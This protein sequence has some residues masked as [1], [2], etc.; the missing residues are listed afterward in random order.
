MT[1]A[2]PLTLAPDRLA[3]LRDAIALEDTA[4]LSATAR[5]AQSWPPPDSTE[6]DLRDDG[7]RW[8][9]AFTWSGFA[10]VVAGV[11]RRVRGG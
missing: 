4:R 10:A 11:V 6:P 1:A 9:P 3:E 7:G 2:D 5:L 8:E